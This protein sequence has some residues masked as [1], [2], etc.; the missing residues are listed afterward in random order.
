MKQEFERVKNDIETIQNVIGLSPTLAHEWILWMKRDIWLFL[1]WCLPG[2]MLIASS[3]LPIGEVR[4]HFGYT[5]AEWT[6]ILIAVVMGG[7]FFATIRKTL[8]NDGRPQSLIR[9]YKRI[10]GL[11][12]AGKLASVAFLVGCVLYVLWAWRF[13]I[14]S[15]AFVSGICILAGSIYLVVAAVS[16]LWLLLG[17]A[18]PILGYGVFAVLV[19][20]NRFAGG[21]PLG[22]TCI[23]IGLS[24]YLIQFWQIRK[25]ERQ[26]ESY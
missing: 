15:A 4:K 19:P 16:R 9:E 6:G 1:W 7:I 24:S 13:R 21:I 18:V 26:N 25:V 8:A 2:A 10:W 23:G 12:S 17:V 3:F 5:L 11:D 20:G 22:I 14:S